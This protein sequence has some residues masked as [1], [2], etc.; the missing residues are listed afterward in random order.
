MI[1]NYKVIHDNDK[2]FVRGLESERVTIP[3]DQFVK[4]TVQQLLSRDTAYDQLNLLER[5]LTLRI[6]GT[7]G[8]G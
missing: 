6:Y 8:N 1:K 5:Q 2:H 3:D 4:A 7:L